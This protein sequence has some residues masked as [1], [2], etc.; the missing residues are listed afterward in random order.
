MLSS[1]RHRPYLVNRPAHLRRLAKPVLFDYFPFPHYF[2]DADPAE[3]APAT[4]EKHLNESSR[5]YHTHPIN[6]FADRH[7][8][9]DPARTLAAVKY[10]LPYT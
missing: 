2:G 6:V 5:S 1:H 4:I 9:S 3:A 7:S 10:L 8:G